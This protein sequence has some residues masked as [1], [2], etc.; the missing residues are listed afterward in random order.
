MAIT[1]GLFVFSFA[2]ELVK[3]TARRPTLHD[4]E[5]K[6]R[7][8][9]AHCIYLVSKNKYSSVLVRSDTARQ[10]LTD[11]GMYVQHLKTHISIVFSYLRPLPV[12]RHSVR[13]LSSQ[14]KNSP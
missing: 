3:D 8:L 13:S 7:T 10:Q 2:V 5:E 4:E 1:L 11:I 9:A 14:M 12:V 6:A